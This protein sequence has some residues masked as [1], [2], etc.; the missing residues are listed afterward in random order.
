MDFD[1]NGRTYHVDRVYDFQGEPRVE[2]H[3][4]VNGQGIGRTWR[5]ASCEL[6]LPGIG[7]PCCDPNDENAGE[8]C[9]DC[10]NR[11]TDAG[12]SLFNT[13]RRIAGKSVYS[14]R[15]TKLED[16]QRLLAEI[17]ELSR[18][19]TEPLKGEVAREVAYRAAPASPIRSR[20]WRVR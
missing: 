8:R 18:A 15:L 14:E 3:C 19:A 5:L 6:P 17:W 13:L 9:A 10:P 2:T 16:A 20:R 7:R 1:H 12:L 11:V 4:V